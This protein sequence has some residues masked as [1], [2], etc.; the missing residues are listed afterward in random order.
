MAVGNIHFYTSYLL[1]FTTKKSIKENT[2][3]V[4]KTQTFEAIFKP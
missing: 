3:K 1:I 4:Y 2:E